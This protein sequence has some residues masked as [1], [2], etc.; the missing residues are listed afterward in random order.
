MLHIDQS[1]NICVLL[2]FFC[3]FVFVVL[4][5]VVETG[6]PGGKPH[7]PWA[8]EL[9]K[10]TKL[11]QSS[12]QNTEWSKSNFSAGQVKSIHPW[13]AATSMCHHEPEPKTLKSKLLEQRIIPAQFLLCYK[14][15]S[16]QSIHALQPHHWASKSLSR[17]ACRP[18]AVFYLRILLLP[19]TASFHSRPVSGSIW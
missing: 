9:K 14:E 15:K 3:L 6:K 17:L 16:I 8:K 2:C 11:M 13:V 19:V 10:I 12:W 7:W 4:K 5:A 1:F 18:Q